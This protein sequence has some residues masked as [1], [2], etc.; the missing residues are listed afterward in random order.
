MYKGFTFWQII[1]ILGD[2]FCFVYDKDG[3]PENLKNIF[4]VGQIAD[5]EDL[6]GTGD[7]IVDTF[8]RKKGTDG[9]EYFIVILSD[10]RDE[11]ENGQLPVYE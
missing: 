1:L 4:E 2:G 11:N 9:K 5:F 3:R 7:R 10:D 6:D 8:E